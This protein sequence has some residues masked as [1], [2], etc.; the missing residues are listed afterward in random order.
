LTW[1]RAV[2]VDRTGPT[3]GVLSPLVGGFYYGG[4]LSGVSTAARA[5]GGVVLAVQTLD[6]GVED[7]ENC[8]PPRLSGTV[9]WER[10][11]G[12]VVVTAALQ[13]GDLEALVALGKPVVVISNPADGAGCPVVTPDNRG[14]V[15]A[16]V[17]HLVGHGHR[18]IAFAGCFGHTDVVERFESYRDTLV[19]AGLT[20][21]PSLLYPVDDTHGTGGEQAAAAMIAAGLPSTAILLGTDLNALGLMSALGEAGFSLPQD[22]AVVGFDG[23]EAGRLCTPSLTTVR[24]DFVDI[25][26][27][28][29][30]LLLRQIAGEQVEATVHLVPTP[31]VVRESCGCQLSEVS[32]S[33]LKDGRAPDRYRESD[34]F[35]DAFNTQYQVNMDLLGDRASDAHDL[36]W[37]Q[38][39]HVS[40]GVLGL[41]APDRHGVTT[42]GQYTSGGLFPSVGSGEVPVAAFPPSEVIDIARGSAGEAVFMVPA[43]SG[44]ADWGWLCVA[45]AV[46]EH[47]AYI[48]RETINQWAAL[49]TA[50]LVVAASRREVVEL[51][52]EL[53]AILENS[54]DAIARYDAEL[55]YRYLNQAA[56]ASFRTAE[57]ELL[58]RTDA[59]LRCRGAATDG[60][61]EALAQVVASVAPTQLDYAQTFGHET[62]WYQARMAPLV[63]DE[64]LLVGVVTSSRDISELKRAEHALTHQTLHD[65]LTGL[66]NRVL[67]LDRLALAINQLERLP[68]SVAV[69]FIDLDHFKEINDTL[70]HE[71]GDRVLVEVGRRLTLLSRRSD[72]LSRFG[73]DEFV[74]LCDRLEHDED[75]RII[76]DRL[77]RS[78]AEP[79]VDGDRELSL[80]AS[81]GIVVVSDPQAD[82]ST[83][84]RNADEAMYNAKAK[85]RDRCYVFDLGMRDRVF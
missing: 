53:G 79:F 6:A 44:D 42:A 55:R 51:G 82:V 24:A 62:Y 39:T 33:S 38:H 34:Y 35:R 73:G 41:W 27:F 57:S 28:A 59:E 77:V 30:D 70:G 84:V 58:G 36:R 61:I 21:D 22:Q 85:G 52:R 37:L 9:G 8:V 16:A 76:G 47:Q 63:D 80:S 68:G 67:F 23:I 12:H 40:A 32:D 4:L 75:V 18:R 10:V 66:P 5:A 49:L 31:L 56:V 25:G 69:L 13:A 48:G 50:A 26:R 11:D 74:L 83:V 7:T 60:W 81:I 72:T 20:Y 29:G 2:S 43:R 17:L 19:E 46:W 71:T 65:S 64:G 3:V 54:P 1:L 14:G 45:T 15:R 78:L